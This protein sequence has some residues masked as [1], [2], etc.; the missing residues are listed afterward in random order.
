MQ[1]NGRVALVGSFPLVLEGL[2]HILAEAG[3][4]VCLCAKTLDEILG[5][6]IEFE[7]DLLLAALPSGELHEH[8]A[9]LFKIRAGYPKVKFVFLVDA[10]AEEDPMLAWPLIDG[11]ILRTIEVK[12]LI[13]A[14]EVVLLGERVVSGVCREAKIAAHPFA[15]EPQAGTAFQLRQPSPRETQLSPREMQVLC[16]LSGG[17]SNKLIARQ[18]GI[19]EA[20][21]KAHMKAILR[22][23][24]A[25][26]RTEAAVW[27][28]SHGLAVNG[29]VGSA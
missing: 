22:K 27:A 18:I 20:T 8:S 3:F 23:L 29:H 26:N 19:S 11:L 10:I 25:R 9:K 24:S 28:K 15:A 16:H 4:F 13:K 14:I 7:P 17:N 12:A 2:K 5:E 21:V 1:E 6:E